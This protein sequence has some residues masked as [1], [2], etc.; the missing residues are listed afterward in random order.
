MTFV[1]TNYPAKR[2]FDSLF[3]EFFSNIPSNWESTNEGLSFGSP[4]VNIHET[5]DA[6]HL[7]VLAAGRNKEDFKL[8]AENG[9][10]TISYEKK[11][12][13]KNDDYKTIRREF[14]FRS[15]KRSFN[16]DET[17]DADK[18]EAKYENGVLKLLLPKKEVV[19]AEV[20][21]INIQ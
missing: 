7:E 21:Q 3:N 13:T 16:L 1:K 10:L 20:K 14:S 17:I 8:N 9:L 15:F 11:E 5:K 12:E 6:Y 19:K 2:T 18:I 4:K